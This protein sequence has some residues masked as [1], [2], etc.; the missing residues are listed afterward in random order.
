MNWRDISSVDFNW[1]YNLIVFKD[2]EANEIKLD[3]SLEDFLLV[4]IM[5]KQNLLKED[6]QEAFRKMRVYNDIFLMNSNNV[7][8]K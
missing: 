7:H 8:L 4:I 2:A 3:V 6:Y 1:V 5:I